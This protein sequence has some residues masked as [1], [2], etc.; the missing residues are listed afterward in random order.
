MLKWNR[1]QSLR[2][3]EGWAA[4]QHHNVFRTTLEIVPPPES[5]QTNKPW[6]AVSLRRASFFA[7]VPV[8]PSSSD[9]FFTPEWHPGNIYGLPRSP[10]QLI[11]LPDLSLT[12]PTVYNIF[13]S[14]DYEV[15]VV[16]VR[17]C[18]PVLLGFC[19]RSDSLET[20]QLLYV[21]SLS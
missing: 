10:K 7:L 15:T 4:F 20:P 19:S 1:W 16:L 17:Q 3:T 21:K 11:D 2:A 9:I 14:G 5:Y 12:H 18:I 13:V 8:Q 6:L